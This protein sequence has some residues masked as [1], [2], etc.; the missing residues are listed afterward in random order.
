MLNNVL[1]RL[2]NDFAKV[3]MGFSGFLTHWHGILTFILGMATKTAIDHNLLNTGSLGLSCQVQKLLHTS[4]LAQ[5]FLLITIIYITFYLSHEK[6]EDSHFLHDPL[7]VLIKTLLFWIF[8]IIS[9]KMSL[10][11]TLII[12]FLMLIMFIITNIQTYK[13]EIYNSKKKKT[14]LEKQKQT[15]EKN[16]L[17]QSRTIVFGTIIL[18]ALFGFVSYARKQYKTYKRV[19]STTKFLFGVRKCRGL[20]KILKK[21]EASKAWH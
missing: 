13:A 2:K 10:A 15:Q 20:R 19:W 7:T 8:L 16:T 4:P 21:Q 14:A 11:P 3:S 1:N 5:Q 9:S 12:V 17:D 6:D 18:V